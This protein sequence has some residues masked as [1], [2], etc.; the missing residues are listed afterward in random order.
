M[1][2]PETRPRTRARQHLCGLLASELDD[3]GRACELFD[4][5]LRSETYCREFSLELLS[6]ARG[7]RG[8]SWEIR[9]LAVLMLEHQILKIPGEDL[10]EFDLLLTSLGLK[11]ETGPEVRLAASLLKEGYTSTDLRSFVPEFRRKL[12][13]LCRVHD[14]VRGTGTSA[15]ALLD[16][17]RLCRQECKLSL[18]RYVFGPDEV[19]ARIFKQVDTSRGVADMT[20]HQSASVEREAALA[21]ARMPDYEAAILARLCAP[22]KIL[23]VSEATSSELNSLV[24]YPLTTVVLTVKPPGSNFEFEIKRAGRRGRHKLGVVFER[25]DEYVPIPH[26]LDGGS[27]NWFLRWEANAASALAEMYRAARRR[28][29][30]VP[31]YHT[32]LSVFGVPLDGREVHLVSYFT[33]PNVFGEKF[34]EM[35]R[36]MRRAVEAFTH[37]DG[38]H[39]PRLPGGVGLGVQFLSHAGPT[40]ALISGTTSFRLDKLSRYLSD[41]GARAYFEGLG[42]APSCDEARGFADAVLEEVLGVYRP[43]EVRYRSHRQYVGAAMRVRENRERADENYVSAMRQIGDFWGT[44]LAVRGYSWGESFVARNVGL[45]SIWREGRWEVRVVFMDHDNLHLG[46]YTKYYRPVTSFRGHRTD[47]RFIIG[48]VTKGRPSR[49]EFYHLNEIYRAGPKLKKRGKGAFRE[50]MRE[51]FREAMAAVPGDDLLTRRLGAVFL[52]GMRDWDDLVK[53][54]LAARDDGSG[55]DAAWRRKR[56]RELRRRGHEQELIETYF[57][58]LDRHGDFIGR[59]EFLY[60]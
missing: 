49:S 4:R 11:P 6:I 43:P 13:R 10:G 50:A 23:W 3:P 22:S 35:S 57:E 8:D 56:A 17:V 40:Q 46:G 37:E 58:A 59:Y 42:R 19:V 12:E 60:R 45:R 47:E 52:K 34:G 18:A 28:D 30:P 7:Q 51:A 14:R 27:M 32:R 55:D 24:E 39:L 25:G 20:T 36:E 9:R 29:A 41:D 44:L 16:F 15:G 31:A 5:L 33:E 26:R 2:R 38:R 53:R 1:K 48:R 54:Y 21:L